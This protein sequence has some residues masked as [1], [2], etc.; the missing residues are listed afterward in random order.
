MI[1]AFCATIVLSL[2]SL[3]RYETKGTVVTIERDHYYWNTSLP[4]LTICPTVNR[5]DREYFNDYC[6][7]RGINGEDKVQFYEF[8][9]SMANAT[10]ETF[11]QIKNYSSVEVRRWHWYC[12][13]VKQW[14]FERVFLQKLNLLPEDYMMLI[15]NM[16]R[17]WTRM[18][19]LEA[20]VRAYRNRQMIRSEQ[21][22]T[23]RGICYVGNNF[24][25][26]N[27]STKLFFICHNISTSTIAT[28]LTLL[29]SLD[30]S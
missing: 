23:E 16:T 11:H 18:P 15:Y 8:L 24:L 12:F 19:N 25:A 27:L 3:N 21:I 20:R 6:Q 7:K 10:F 13:P 1:C 2:K 29:S 14:L 5:I 4:S 28:K 30:I 17:D 26:S 9:E 22:L